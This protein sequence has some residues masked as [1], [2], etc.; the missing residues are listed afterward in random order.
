VFPKDIWSISCFLSK[1]GL[2]GV[3]ETFN[4]DIVYRIIDCPQPEE[5][6]CPVCPTCCHV[7]ESN[8]P[9]RISIITTTGVDAFVQECFVKAKTKKDV[10]ENLN[11]SPYI[12]GEWILYNENIIGKLNNKVYIL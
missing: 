5:C 4:G 3:K 9:E 11:N 8:I 1:Y 2:C 10:V 7:P 12:K 6:D